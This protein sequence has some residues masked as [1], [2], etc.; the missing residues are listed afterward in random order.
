MERRSFLA[1]MRGGNLTQAVAMEAAPP[2]VA[3]LDKYNGVWD[4]RMTNHLLRR[5]T[6]GVSYSQLVNAS[7]LGM[8]GLVNQLFS[9]PTAIAPPLNVDFVDDAEVPVGTTWV[10]AKFGTSAN[11]TN[12]RLRSIQSW[13]AQNTLT[14]EIHIRHKMAIFWHNHF[15]ISDVI[16]ARYLWKYIN[17]FYDNYAGNFKNLVN[18]ITVDPSMLRFLNGNLNTKRSPNENYAR[19]LLE[20]FTIG[21]GPIAGPGDYTNYTETDILAIAKVL[22]GWYDAGYQNSTRSGFSSLFAAANHEIAD[23]QL[24]NRFGNAVIKN[25]NAN[26]YKDLIN[27]IFSKDEVSRYIA[28][29]LYRHFVYYKIDQ[30]I[31][32]GII[33]PMSKLIRNNNYEIKPALVA[34]LSSQHFYDKK[35]IG[36]MI[37]NP[38]DFMANAGNTLGLTLSSVLT[39]RYNYLRSWASYSGNILQMSTFDLP[40]VAGWKAYYQTPTFYQGWINSV[41]LPSRI[42]FVNILHKTGSSRNGLSVMIDAAVFAQTTSKPNDINQL[43]ADVSLLML[44]KAPTTAQLARFRTILNGTK[45]DQ[46]WK[47]AYDSWRAAPNDANLKRGINDSVRALLAYI[48]YM[49][50]YQLS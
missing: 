31:E 49:P 30:E 46:S 29:K 42:Q 34:L 47:E 14:P 22:T 10:N 12:Y 36:G 45:T 28:R 7:N 21:K 19:E 9:T 38:Q 37:K 33:E 4:V 39:T 44:P 24:S 23:K 1:S 11:V 5:T 40:S 27:I 18:E 15:A 8:D 17:L 48:S 41:T 50:E 25:N 35:I 43:I 32:D 26:E 16:D 3:T 13:M 6:F 20:L 2:L